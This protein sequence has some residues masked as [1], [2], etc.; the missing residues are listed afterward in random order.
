MPLKQY[1]TVK[2]ALGDLDVIKYELDSMIDQ[3]PRLILSVHSL[4]QV[5]KALE[6]FLPE[7]NPGATS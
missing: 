7:P 2:E 6:S 1:K 3:N 4:E 5:R